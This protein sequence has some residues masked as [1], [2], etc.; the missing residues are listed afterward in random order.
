M[1]NPEMTVAELIEKVNRERRENPPQMPSAE[2]MI[3]K[4]KRA[5]RRHQKNGPA[6]LLDAVDYRLRQVDPKSDPWT[7]IKRMAKAHNNPA[8]ESAYLGVQ[9]LQEDAKRDGRYHQEDWELSCETA[10]IILYMLERDCA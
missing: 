8:Y 10:E 4:A 2:A 1:A 7:V 5:L 6:L 9:S 3:E